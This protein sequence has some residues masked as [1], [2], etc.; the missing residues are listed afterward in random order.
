MKQVAKTDLSVL[1]TGDTGTGKD[2][3]AKDLHQFS[4]RA[5][6]PFVALNVAAIPREVLEGQLFGYRRGAFTGAV[7]DAK[8][9]IREAEGGTLFID[10][11]GDLSPDLQPKLLRFLESGEIQPLGERPQRVDVRIIAATNARLE[12]LISDGRFREDLFYRLNVVTLTVPPLRERREEI[13]TLI[14]HFLALHAKQASRPIPQ[15]TARALDCLSAYDWPGNVRQL[16]NELRRLVALS[17]EDEQLDIEHLAHGI[18]NANA[19]PALNRADGSSLTLHLDRELQDLYDD[20]ERAAIARAMSLSRQNQAESAR[21]LGI[22][23]KGLYLK[24]KRL[25]LLEDTTA[26]SDEFWDDKPTAT[27]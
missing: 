22:T 7:N 27:R 26:D 1:V 5:S 3:V 4:L 9:L 16:T 17:E 25:G 11:I 23:R 18:R 15:I 6:K 21:R 2:V 10:E 19:K 20:L 14:N 13:P 8:G 12:A 24:R